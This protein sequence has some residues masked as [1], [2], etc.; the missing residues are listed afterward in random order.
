MSSSGTHRIFR[1][2]YSHSSIY[3]KLRDVRSEVL[4][5]AEAHV[6]TRCGAHTGSHFISIGGFIPRKIKW[7][8]R[9]AEHSSPSSGEVTNEW[10][11]NSRPAIRLYVVSRGKFTFYLSSSGRVQSKCVGTR[12]RT[13]GEVKGKLANGV[14]SQYLSHYLGTWCTTA[15]GWLPNCS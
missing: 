13:A 7:P 8:E 4:P 2:I 14:G 12:W 1:T 15:T 5:P 10:S 9:E 11:Y 3:P 6:P